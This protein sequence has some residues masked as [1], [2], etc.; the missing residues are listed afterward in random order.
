MFFVLRLCS[1]CIYKDLQRKKCFKIHTRG[2]EGK[3]KTGPDNIKPISS[4]FDGSCKGLFVY[5]ACKT[6]D[7]FW[8][9]LHNSI[10]HG[11]TSSTSEWT[12]YTRKFS[13]MRSALHDSSAYSRSLLGAQWYF[14]T[15]ASNLCVVCFC[16]RHFKLTGVGS[17]QCSASIAPA[18]VLNEHFEDIGQDEFE[19]W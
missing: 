16:D 18:E 15:Q 3:F 9:M 12:K 2:S 19:R 1:T 7:I 17:L 4:V 6:T 5:G 11:C 10:S 13:G 14:D 8:N